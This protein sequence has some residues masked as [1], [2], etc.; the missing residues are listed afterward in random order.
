[1]GGLK[2][3]RKRTT[4]CENVAKVQDMQVAKLRGNVIQKNQLDA[5]SWFFCITLPTLMM[6]GQTKIK[7]T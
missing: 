1:M 5:S 3:Y 2:L 6:H 7:F 4:K